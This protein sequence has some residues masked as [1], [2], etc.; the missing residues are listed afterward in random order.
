M[1]LPCV[2][3]TSIQVLQAC[4]QTP[5]P[6]QV[7]PTLGKLSFKTISYLDCWEIHLLLQG[8]INLPPTVII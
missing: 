6:L 4:N 8:K 3:S 5:D 1:Y 7:L 2:L